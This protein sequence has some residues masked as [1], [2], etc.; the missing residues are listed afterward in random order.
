[1]T[2]KLLKT[3]WA[4][5][6]LLLSTLLMARETAP[7][8]FYVLSL[9]WSPEYC[10]IR[11]EDRQCGRG[12]GFVLHGLWPQYEKGWPQNC[13]AEKLSKPLLQQYPALYPSEKLA[14][15]EWSKHGTCS[16]LAPEAYLQ[17]SQQLK[18]SFKT[19]VELDH[20]IQPLRINARQLSQSIVAAN[21]HLNIEALAFLC[22]GGGRFL[23]EIHVCYDKQGVTP[24]SCSSEMQRQ[25]L[26]SCGQKDF[27]IR[28]VR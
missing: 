4:G 27:L 20:L 2:G 5:I 24:I 25:S 3:L 1:M 16:G 7:F 8:D 9:S 13:G 10:V 28:N 19:P 12:Y 6:P 15:H 18:Q 21:P 22:T 26:K 23:Q 11:P 17:L 14:F